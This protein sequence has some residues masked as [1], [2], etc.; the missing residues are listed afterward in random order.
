VKP[1][2][3]IRYENRY[4][5]T[6]GHTLLPKTPIT[7]PTRVV[8]TS[9]VRRFGAC[10]R[11]LAPLSLLVL[12]AR[13]PEAQPVSPDRALASCSPPPAPLSSKL[14][15]RST[16]STAPTPVG[17]VGAIAASPYGARDS[18][19]AR[20]LP[21]SAAVGPGVAAAAA[22][23]GAL[24]RGVSTAAATAAAE[25][26]ALHVLPCSR[27]GSGFKSRRNSTIKKCY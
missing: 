5:H 19:F 25:G 11:L 1:I 3:A 24:P 10:Y 15:A 21:A 8:S 20:S 2:L 4:T 14:R 23:A 9:Q 12:H 27:P 13:A 22:A 26:A 7:L 6:L 18:A 16:R 17:P